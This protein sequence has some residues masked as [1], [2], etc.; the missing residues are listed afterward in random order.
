MINIL[1]KVFARF[2]AAVI[3]SVISGALPI[4]LASIIGLV[5]AVM[6]GTLQP[7]EA[8]AGFG[9]GMIL[10]IVAAFLVGRGVVNSGLGY[11]VAYLLVQRFGGSTLG[12][13][14]SIIATDALIAPAFAS[15]TARSGV[16]YPSPSEDEPNVRTSK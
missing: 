13:G 10:L 9:E 12:L 3:F 6:T 2:F 14:Y 16:L 7:T 11:R 4:V 15:N 5:A 8:Y 1:R